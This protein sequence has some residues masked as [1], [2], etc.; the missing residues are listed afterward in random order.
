[1]HAC[2]LNCL[3]LF[4]T[5]MDCSLSGSTIPGI[6]QARILEWVAIFFSRWSSQ[7]R[8]WTHIS[9]IGRCVLYPWASW[10]AQVVRQWFPHFS[11]HQSN[12]EDL[13]KDHVLDP[14]RSIS[15]STDLGWEWESACPS[16]SQVMPLVLFWG[17][18]L[19]SCWY[20]TIIL[21]QSTTLESPGVAFSCRKDWAPAK[22]NQNLY[23]WVWAWW[24]LTLPRW[25]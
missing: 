16:G 22:P 5:P 18:R 13:W 10:E 7:L 15:D 24:P 3:Q 4:V 2:V 8:D 14:T 12:Q 11:A 25:F 6:L 19:E 1:M 20:K 9:C 23:R 21:K 17:L